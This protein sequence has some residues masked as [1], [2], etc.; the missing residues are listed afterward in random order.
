[1]NF[2]PAIVAWQVFCLVRTS[3]E[4]GEDLDAAVAAQER[5]SC[6]V[7]DE[8]SEAYRELVSIGARHPEA[9][10]FGE[11]L[12]YTTWS[13]LM[14]E[15]VAEHFQ[16]GLALCRVLLQREPDG[17]PERLARLRAMERSFRSGL[18]EKVEDLLDYETDTLKGGD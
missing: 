16:R 5:F 7:G 9:A 4:L 14:D 12:V 17:D 6:G 2:D 8:A 15:T 11:F 13:H 18:G 1:M 10:A 3:T